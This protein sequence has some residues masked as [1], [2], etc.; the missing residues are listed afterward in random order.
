MAGQIDLTF[1]QVASALAQVRSG[2]L[3]PYAVMAKTRWAGQI[4]D[5]WSIDR[6]SSA[7]ALLIRLP[8]SSLS[9]SFRIP[10]EIITQS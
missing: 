8:I 1:T 5:P 10:A 2:Q 6:C 9:R 7:E 3:K 4:G